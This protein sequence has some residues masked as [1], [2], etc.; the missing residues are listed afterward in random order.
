MED[1]HQKIDRLMQ[2]QEEIMRRLDALG[3]TRG[4]GENAPVDP[5]S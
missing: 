1:L 3:T 5:A 2:N 4:D